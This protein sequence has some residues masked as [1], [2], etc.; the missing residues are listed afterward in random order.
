M[1]SLEGKT[2][3]VTGGSR[4]IG[5]AA[6]QAL[7]REGASIILHYN[8][9]LKAAEETAATIRGEVRLVQADIGSLQ[10]IDRMFEELKNVRLDCLIN[11]A[12]IWRGTPMGSSTSDAVNEMLNTN[13]R[14]PFWV[15]QC[16]LPLLNDGARIVNI[17]S[18]AGR[19]GVVGGRSLYGA[20]KAAI[21]NLT[22]S[23]ALELA[24]RKILVN[25]IA[26]GYIATDMTDPF[27][28]DPANLE[29]AIR[30][31]PMGK[32]GEPEEVADV[33]VFLCSEASRF[34]TGQSI[35]VSGGSI[36]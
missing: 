2:A 34:V 28:S 31:Q 7:A 16:A 24:P 15:T 21:D 36:I 1:G 6:C 25:S 35:N 5:R 26:P 11:N 4:G 30:R 20:T 18:V 9:N 3:L 14:G 23:W 8:S 12:G 33:V 17:S 22:K 10:E 32:I 29:S 19:I 13:L 27:F